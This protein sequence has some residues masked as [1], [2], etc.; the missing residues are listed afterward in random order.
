MKIAV[1]VTVTI[2]AGLMVV[3]LL[4][5]FEVIDI[6]TPTGAKRAPVQSTGTEQIDGHEQPEPP[7][8]DF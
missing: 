7:H 2:L 8:K 5:H 1:V 4:Q 6:T 3:F